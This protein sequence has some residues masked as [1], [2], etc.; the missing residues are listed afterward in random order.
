[1]AQSLPNR[2]VLTLVKLLVVIGIIAI[3]MGLLLPAVQLAREAARR[4]S[5]GSQMR[6]LGLAAANYESAK[7]RFPAGYTG[8]TAPRRFNTWFTTLL[9]YL[10]QSAVYD[11][12]VADYAATP[13]PFT[14]L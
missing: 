4:T 12:M 8:P 3:L 2:N 10:E 1:M 11:Q 5:C 14:S 6:Q 7:G 9:P 13:D